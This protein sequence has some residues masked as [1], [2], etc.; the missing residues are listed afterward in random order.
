MPEENISQE[1]RLKNTDETKNYF[2]RE[3]QNK[4][5]MIENLLH[6]IKV[7][8]SSKGSP[9][10]AIYEKRDAKDFHSEI[11][12]VPLIDNNFEHNVSVSNEVYDNLN[13]V[14]EDECV[15]MI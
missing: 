13:S 10:I 14:I 6:T 12:N 7:L 8:T 11:F 5:K 2:I 1:F 4:D 9:D 3:I 15:V